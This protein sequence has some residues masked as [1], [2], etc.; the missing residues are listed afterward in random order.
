[1]RD[2]EMHEQLNDSSSQPLSSEGQLEVSP[3]LAEELR[4]SAK[5]PRPTLG[6]ILLLP[7]RYFRNKVHYWR[8]ERDRK[9]PVLDENGLPVEWRHPEIYDIFRPSQQATWEAFEQ[10][11]LARDI[12]AIPAPAESVIE[13]LIQLP[14]SERM[15][16][17]YTI[18]DKHE[19]I[20]W[21]T[22]A[23]PQCE[24]H[25]GYLFKISPEGE[26]TIK[27][28]QEEFIERFGL[29]DQIAVAQPT[30]N[31]TDDE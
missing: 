16:V 20:Y 24:L 1:M 7:L 6:N 10:W 2:V 30:V 29:S 14:P 21:H 15:E 27:K 8:M 31:S 23:C 5:P 26:M 11:C 9:P 3:E 12:T 25:L 18:A 28:A 13:Y 19:S 22:G 4:R 17:Y